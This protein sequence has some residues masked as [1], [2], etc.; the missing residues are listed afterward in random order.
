[1]RSRTESGIGRAATKPGGASTLCGETGRCTGETAG[2][3]VLLGLPAL[4]L[5]GA[6]EGAPVI[7]DARI[8]HRIDRGAS[9]M[10]I[11]DTGWGG[12]DGERASVPGLGRGRSPRL[13]MSRVSL[14]FPGP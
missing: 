5:T 8:T 3:P 12:G 4:V 11:G 1:M 9:R 13:G 6:A 10:G 2:F 7:V 14:P